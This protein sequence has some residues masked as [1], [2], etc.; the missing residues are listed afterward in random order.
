MPT[1]VARFTAHGKPRGRVAPASSFDYI[2]SVSAQCQ[3]EAGAG[4]L[5]LLGHLTRD[6]G[7][8]FDCVS[9]ASSRLL[10]GRVRCRWQRIRR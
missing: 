9:S 3:Q 10:T 6:V 2:L 5:L 7:Q 4:V 8:E 1:M